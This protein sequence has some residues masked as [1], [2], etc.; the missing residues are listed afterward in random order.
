MSDVNIFTS[1]SQEENR[2]TNGL[3]S[4][5][6]LTR[7]EHPEFVSDFF[8]D[9]LGIRTATPLNRFRVLSEVV[10]HVDA[11]IRSADTCMLFETKIVSVALR[12]DQIDRHL[13]KLRA[14]SEPHKYLVLLTPDDAQSNYISRCRRSAPDMIRHLA[15][16]DVLA[17]LE[18]FAEL[19]PERTL[20]QLIRHFLETIRDTVIRQDM[21]GIIATISFGDHSE[22][23]PIVYLDG[24]RQGIRKCWRTPKEYKQLSGTRRK[25]LLYDPKVK[26]ITV[27][28]E[29][30]EVRRTDEHPKYSWSNDFADG[31]LQVL[32]IP[33][34]RDIIQSVPGL[35]TFG[36]GRSPFRKITHEQFVQLRIENVLGMQVE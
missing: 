8:S 4:I 19:R 35:E 27:V 1:F 2:F 12:T 10:G 34:S 7:I 32:A 22:V 28:V 26:A 31:T 5:L 18:R 17:Y 13:E 16:K 3:F 36:K 9:L 20:S 25:L 33:V 15:W 30:S 6:S 23:Y 29:I 11:D 14:Q 24:I 21:A